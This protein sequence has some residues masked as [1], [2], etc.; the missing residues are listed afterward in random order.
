MG[1][2]RKRENLGDPAIASVRGDEGWV[3]AA[4]VAVEGGR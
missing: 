3:R 2:Q 4:V 1:N